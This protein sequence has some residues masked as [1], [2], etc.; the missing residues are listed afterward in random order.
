MRMG[1]TCVD[2]LHLKILALNVLC[3]DL[4]KCPADDWKSKMCVVT[5]VYMLHLSGI[6]QTYL[7]DYASLCLSR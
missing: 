4:L 1:L 6:H 3:P 2:A 7:V 5:Q